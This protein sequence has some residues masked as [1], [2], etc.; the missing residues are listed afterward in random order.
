M[1]LPRLAGGVQIFERR[2]VG[3]GFHGARIVQHDALRHALRAHHD[4]LPACAASPSPATAPPTMA[5]APIS[6]P[7]MA[8]VLLRSISLPH[9]RQMPAGDMAGLMGENAD[10]LIRRLGLGQKPGMDED[11]LAAGDEGV[12]A[13]IVDQIDVH[14]AG[15]ETG[16]LEDRL[17]I[18]PH[19]AFDLGVADE[20]GAACRFFCASAGSASDAKA[21]LIADRTAMMRRAP[22]LLADRMSI[23][24]SGSNEA[25]LR[26]GT[27]S[28]NVIN[29]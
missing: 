13:R 21:R 18:E 20:R 29:W 8:M 5:A 6:M 3:G 9:A 23:V 2:L 26:P 11:A 15:I 14:R 16:R 19:Q 10:H 17:G 25:S 4:A 27:A 28:R 12:D 7:M 24:L 22:S 1:P